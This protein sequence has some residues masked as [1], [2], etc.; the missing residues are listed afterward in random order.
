MQDR[1]LRETPMIFFSKNK[2]RE[3]TKRLTLPLPQ[4]RND[5]QMGRD[6]GSDSRLEKTDT[7][8]SD[9]GVEGFRETIADDDSDEAKLALIHTQQQQHKPVEWTL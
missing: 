7:P 5:T 6:E 3:M 4:N 8:H 1:I 2:R 9:D